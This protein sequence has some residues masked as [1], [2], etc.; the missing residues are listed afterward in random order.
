MKNTTLTP[1]LEDRLRGCLL[2]LMCGDALGGPIEFHSLPD[3]RRHYPHGVRDM[4]PGWGMTRDRAVGDITDDSEMAISLLRSLVRCGRYEPDDARESY[5]DW[6]GTHPADV[7]TT[8]IYGLAGECLADSQANGAL[9]RIAPLAIFAA[10]TPAC[11]WKAAADADAGLTHIHPRCRHA[12]VIYIESLLLALRG[13]GPA[14]IHEAALRRAEEL[15]DDSLVARLQA[16]VNEEP[17][18]EYKCGWVEVA[19]QAT[20]Y[21]LLHAEDYPS[22]ICAIV[23]RLGDPDTNAAI[24]G[25]L[26]GVRYGEKG[27]PESWRRAVVRGSQ[28]RPYAYRAVA[29]MKLLERLLA[30]G[31]V[32]GEAPGLTEAE[33]AE[34]VGVGLFGRIRK[35]L[36]R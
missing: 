13:E 14:A 19:F 16:A 28:E 31:I 29:G 33:L 34:D 22:A 17:D 35:W 1:E 11:D 27:I 21:W 30:R 7:G 36:G 25:A 9:M 12:N 24:A 18:Y 26:L 2:G 5:R 3:I 15:H 23:N 8:T 6:L 4:V 20:Y 10:L 32:Q